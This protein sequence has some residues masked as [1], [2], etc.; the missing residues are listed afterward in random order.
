MKQLFFIL[1]LAFASPVFSQNNEGV[2]SYTVEVQNPRAAEIRARMKERG[3]NFDIPDVNTSSM[4]LYF[5]NSESIFREKP[6]EEEAYEGREIGSGGN[7]RFRFW[8][9][10]GSMNGYY[11]TLGSTAYLQEKDIMGKKFL[12]EDEERKYEWKITGRTEQLGQYQVIEAMTIND[13]DTIQAWFT[14]QIPVSSGPDSYSQLPG[15]ILRVDVNQGKKM[16][17]ATNIDIRPLT[18]EEVIEKPKKGKK[19]TREDFEKMRAEKMEEM[20]EMYGEERAR[21][22]MD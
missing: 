19:V 9:A 11:R 3:M 5:N 7:V 18:E 1:L 6:K 13:V 14:P 10:G 20:K 16:I 2:V 15:L 8:G 17:Y 4:N 12:V 22:W 21:R